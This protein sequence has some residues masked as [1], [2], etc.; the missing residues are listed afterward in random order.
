[1]AHRPQWIRTPQID[2][3]VGDGSLEERMRASFDVRRTMTVEE[4]LHNVGYATFQGHVMSWAF[5]VCPMKV[6][7]VAEDLARVFLL[8]RV[9][10]EFGGGHTKYVA[11]STPVEECRRIPYR[12]LFKQR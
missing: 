12:S 7:T 8:A 1:M 6:R 3:L 2:V 11:K 4:R 5:K 9:A 10:E